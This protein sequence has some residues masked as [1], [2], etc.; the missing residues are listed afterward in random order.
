M[1]VDTSAVLA[2]LFAEEDASRY[3]EAIAGADE[4]LISAA[5]Y[6]E[7]AIVIDNQVDAAAGRQFDALMSR[8]GGRVSGRACH[9]AACRPR[10]PGVSRLRQGQ[11]CGAS[12]LRRL[13]RLCVVEGDGPAVALQG[14]RFLED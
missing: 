1:I 10:P 12:E 5:N 3:A 4:R 8:A 14:R 2:I 13:L 11:S 6:L 9:P 7:A